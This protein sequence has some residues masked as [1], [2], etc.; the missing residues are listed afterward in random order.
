MIAPDFEL[1]I[2]RC[3][4]EAV[5]QNFTEEHFAWVLKGLYSSQEE[6]VQLAATVI[7]LLPKEYVLRLLDQWDQ[8]SLPAKKS[9]LIPMASMEFYEPYPVLIQ[10]LRL[11]RDLQYGWLLIQCLGR[12][13][14]FVFPLILPWLETEDLIVL[15]RFKQV[16]SLIGLEKIRLYVQ[17]VPVLPAEQVFRDVFG[18]A[19]IQTL[20]GR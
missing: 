2:S 11:T 14:Y 9:L 6:E 5:E 17:M 18:E 7:P 20:R 4:Y 12:T 19:T 13:E 10:D 8:F 3:I 15:G 1:E 16:L